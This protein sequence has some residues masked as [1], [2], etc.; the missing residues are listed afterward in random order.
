MS[1][2]NHI[3]KL[4]SIAVSVL[5]CAACSC[6]T[7]SEDV[8]VFDNIQYI[9][10]FPNKST[11]P[12]GELLDLG[13]ISP[14]S[15]VIQDS[16]LIV[17]TRN[18]IG[19]LSFFNL[20]NNYENLG[21]YL[22]LGRAGNEFL[23][24]PRISDQLVYS[25]GK[26]IFILLLDSMKGKGMK[27]DVTQTIANKT[28]VYTPLDVEL[29]KAMKYKIRYISEDCILA[30]E[31]SDDKR[32][33]TRYYIKDNQQTT[34]KSMEQLDEV[35]LRE[36]ADINALG[37]FLSSNPNGNIAV[38]VPLFLNYINLYSVFDLSLAKTI[39]IG[40]ELVGV[41]SVSFNEFEDKVSYFKGI[42]PFDS[43]FGV[44]YVNV[45]QSEFDAKDDLPMDIMLFD[46]SGNPMNLLTG[47]MKYN[48]FT[49]DE[50]MA[51]LYT[52]NYDTEEIRLYNVKSIFEK[53]K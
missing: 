46:W 11:L 3:F 53:S 8:V 20:N 24:F 27:I 10:E 41:N 26:S 7:K 17:S 31:F 22:A 40:K 28:L 16:I 38:E 19:M 5:L 37:M 4:K 29:S 6:A 25:D 48:F 30:N 52:I 45:T 2:M 34:T 15:L 49:I 12:E 21:S 13:L 50:Q 51:N 1:Y 44:S 18:V 43:F 42:T 32:K 33:L 35:V 14:N 47:A 39:C 9:T 23:S 36:G